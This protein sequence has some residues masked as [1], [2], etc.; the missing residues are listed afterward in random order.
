MT[1]CLIQQLTFL[2]TFFTNLLQEYFTDL[3]FLK[4]ILWN[5][6]AGNKGV[7]I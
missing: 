6:P 7:S 3:Y 2:T 5:F 1:T 4:K